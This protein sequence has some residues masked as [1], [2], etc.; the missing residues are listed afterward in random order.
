MQKNESENDGCCKDEHRFIKTNPDQKTV[1]SAFQ[2]LQ[3][4]GN[5]LPNTFIE[6]EAIHFPSITEK[7]PDYNTTPRNCGIAVYKRNC[8]FRI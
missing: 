5:A 6:T 3:L 4:A 2:I 7:N 1:E 8:V